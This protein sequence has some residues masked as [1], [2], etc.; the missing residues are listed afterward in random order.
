MD[1][2]LFVVMYKQQKNIQPY[3]ILMYTASL[4]GPNRS[5]KHFLLKPH[6]CFSCLLVG[7]PLKHLPKNREEYAPNP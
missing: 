1:L 4:L 5:Q 6:F 7:R 2:M 3:V